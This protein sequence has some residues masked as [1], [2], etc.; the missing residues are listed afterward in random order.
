MSLAKKA[1]KGGSWYAAFTFISQGFSWLVTFWVARLL[2]PDDYG[3]MALATILTGYAS[4]FSE[5]GLGAAIIQRESCSKEE[6][7][8]VFWFATGVGLLLGILCFPIAVFSAWFFHEPRLVSLTEA[9]GIIFLF[10]G[11]QIVHGNL[12]R[13]EL[14]FKRL[15]LIKMIA[16]FISCSYMLPAAYLGAGVWALLGGQILRALVSSFML[17]INANWRPVWHFDIREISSYIRYGVKVALGRT[18]FYITD[19]SDK[20]IVGKLLGSLAVGYYSFALQLSQIPTEKITVMIN[21]IS[22][23]LFSR[24][25]DSKAEVA[26]HYLK[27]I[28]MIALLVLPLFVGGFLVAKQLVLIILGEKWMPIVPLFK[29]LCLAQIM[30]SLSA[31]NNI[32]HN[33][34]GN[35]ELSLH[36]NGYCAVFMTGSFF[37][38][39]KYFGLDALIFPWVI[40][41]VILCTAWICYTLSKLHIDFF[42]Y[43]KN[44]SNILISI[45][46]MT[47]SI[48]VFKGYSQGLPIFKEGDVLSLILTIMIGGMVYIGAIAILDRKYLSFVLSLIGSKKG[49]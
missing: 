32:V 44:M 46:I 13:R 29:Y 11:V 9:V 31:I 3:L 15:G 35:P 20:F 26:E 5:L 38:A 6:L 2:N 37:V 33:A 4:W 27:I 45:G 41:Y 8:S 30:T 14:S 40:T 17:Y 7:S 39:A 23:P 1:F 21:Q 36:F 19:N 10:N 25:Q 49:F 22:F 28:K 34:L 18:L 48:Y 43:L 12:L 24:L 47:F 42:T 16:V